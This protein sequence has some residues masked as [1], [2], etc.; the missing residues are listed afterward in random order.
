MKLTD[1]VHYNDYGDEWYFQVLSN[2]PWFALIDLVVQ[3]DD[4][5]ASEPFP[6]ILFGIGPEVVFGF[7]IR[8]KRFQISCDFFDFQPRNLATYRRHKSGDYRPEA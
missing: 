6:S 7:S 1:F 2:Y 3:W 4:Y 5:A 8:Y